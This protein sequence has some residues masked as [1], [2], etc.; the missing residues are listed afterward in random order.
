[1]KASDNYRQKLRWPT[2][3]SHIVWRCIPLDESRE[4]FAGER[5]PF[6][7]SKGAAPL[8]VIFTKRDG[9]LV[10]ET[11]QIVEQITKDSPEITVGRSAKK[12]ARGRAQHLVTNRVNDLEG[13]LRRL[14]PGD[15]AVAFLTTSKSV[16]AW[17]LDY[18]LVRRT[19]LG[20]TALSEF[21]RA[22]MGNHRS[23][24]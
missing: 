20:E 12:E 15:D 7:W 18:L 24:K 6:R 5:A 1:M 22:L 19:C 23:R 21:N 2:N 16:E 13:E 11:S 17:S 8:V 9:A 3:Q 14:N 10:K 4:L